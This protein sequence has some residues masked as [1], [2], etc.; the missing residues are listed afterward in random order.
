[1]KSKLLYL[2]LLLIFASCKKG[3]LHD[4]PQSLNLGTFDMLESSLERYPYET[5]NE[6]VIFSD[7]LGNEVEGSLT[8]FSQSYL[9]FS[10][11]VECIDNRDSSIRVSFEAE[12]KEVKIY[13]ESLDL[14]FLV[15]FSIEMNYDKYDNPEYADRAMTRLI[16]KELTTEFP[17]IPIVLNQRTSTEDLTHWSSPVDEIII[18]SKRFESVYT[19]NTGTDIMEIYF[20][21]EHGLIGFEDM[22]T[23]IMY[24]FERVE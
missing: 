9:T 16:N 6:K 23:G 15:L 20:N 5:G 19:T 11:N 12:S 1:M 3:K 24:S 22:T 2:S 10:A 14:R 21:L 4:C 8:F 7:S 17:T 13:F 18:N